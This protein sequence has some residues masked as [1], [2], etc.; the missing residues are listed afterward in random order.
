MGKRNGGRWVLLLATTLFTFSCAAMAGVADVHIA[1]ASVADP[2]QSGAADCKTHP[3]PPLEVRAYDP[4]TFV[5]RQSL[6]ST[7]EA[8]FIYLLIGKSRALLIDTGDVAD[9][10]AMPLAQ[11]VFALLRQ[12]VVS[13]PPL[14][15]VHTH[16]HLD[17]RAADPQF[18][19]QPN[20]EVVGYDLAAVQH[21]YKFTKWPSSRAQID[22]GDRTVDVIPT[23]GHNETDLAFYDHATTLLFS[24]D[25]LLP[26]RLLIDDTV[27]ARAS[28]RR[29][30][31][32]LKD[33]PV[34]AILGGHIE[35]DAN[36]QLL[37]WQSE[38]HPDERPLPLDKSSLLELPAALDRFNGV[39]SQVGPFVME[40]ST[41]ILALIGAA[42]MGVLVALVAAC[43]KFMRRPARR[44]VRE[45]QRS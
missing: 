8:P 15:V 33:E 17:H 22:L 12:A 42:A 10:A 39:Y 41:R 19:G 14:L 43:I 28:A 6:C 29:L 24:G 40:N 36:G 35:M 21:F 38:F 13:R 34:A 45:A 5:L 2:W 20:V 16:R 32:F 3:L 44:A 37:P 31:D 23:P 11:T 25:F 27:A 18:V 9:P 7:F 1:T 30:V 26:G 4:R